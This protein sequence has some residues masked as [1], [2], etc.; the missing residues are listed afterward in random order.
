MTRPGRR[1]RYAALQQMA[2]F[3]PNR[4]ETSTTLRLV[5]GIFDAWMGPGETNLPLRMAAAAGLFHDSR[6]LADRF[7]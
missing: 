6:M 4:A 3:Y 5:I 2:A 1:Q 7:T